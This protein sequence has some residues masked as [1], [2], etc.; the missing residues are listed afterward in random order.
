MQKIYETPAFCIYE[1]EDVFLYS[2]E[3]DLEPDMKETNGGFSSLLRTNWF[4]F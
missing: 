1:V 2:G 3:N 4:P